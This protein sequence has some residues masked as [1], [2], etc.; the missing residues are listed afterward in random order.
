[1]IPGLLFAD[2]IA[3]GSFTRNGLQKGIVKFCTNWSL[4]CYLK[5]TKVM[6]LKK[7][8]KH[9]KN[10]YW[11]MEGQKLDIMNGIVNLGV[12]VG[13]TGG[14]RKHNARIRETGTQ[15]LGAVGRCLMRTPDMKID[16][17]G[18]INEM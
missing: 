2:F 5:K 10:E 8:G 11:Y 4:K 17:L 13:S 15:T 1:M 16:M 12:K 18:N 9:K 6:V 3:V 7:E 14:W